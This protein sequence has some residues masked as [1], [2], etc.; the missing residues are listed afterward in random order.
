MEKNKTE[1]LE[2]LFN[3]QYVLVQV[4]CLV[5]FYITWQMKFEVI[6]Q[7]ALSLGGS[8]D[9]SNCTYF[10]V[11]HRYILYVQLS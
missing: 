5:I 6:K 2:R 4:L 9:V 11:Y 10:L 8:T 7:E 1:T 3:K